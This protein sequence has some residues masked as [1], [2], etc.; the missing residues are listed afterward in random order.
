M[1][2]FSIASMC[3]AHLFNIYYLT[4]KKKKKK[5]FMMGAIFFKTN[6]KK[7]KTGFSKHCFRLDQY[8]NAL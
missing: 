2:Y 8:K 3:S 5:F 1:I 7:G 4:K 6:K